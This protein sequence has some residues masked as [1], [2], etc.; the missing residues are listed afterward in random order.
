[1]AIRTFNCLKCVKLNVF[2]I[3][4]AL[5]DSINLQGKNKK[6]NFAT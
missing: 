3:V 4:F 2:G 6:I 5:W 1:M